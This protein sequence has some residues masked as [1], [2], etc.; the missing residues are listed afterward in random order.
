MDPISLLDKLQS[1]KSQHNPPIKVHYVLYLLAG[2][3]NQ[4]ELALDSFHRYF[5]CLHQDK[6]QNQFALL[7]LAILLS[8][9]DH[10]LEA[11]CVI[12]VLIF[13]LTF[14]Y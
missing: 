7:N 6:Q 8:T 12:T 11:A 5:D 13:I 9:F 3:L 1:I 10:S 4:Y 14:R 2:K